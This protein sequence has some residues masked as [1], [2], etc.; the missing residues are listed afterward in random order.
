MTAF[1]RRVVLKRHERDVRQRGWTLPEASLATVSFLQDLSLDYTGL[2]GQQRVVR[3]RKW[4][5]KI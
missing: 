4:G 5:D 3:W 1:I 2:D